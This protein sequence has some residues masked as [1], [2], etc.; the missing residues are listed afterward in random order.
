MADTTQEARD[1][2]DLAS[3]LPQDHPL[4]RLGR[5]RLDAAVRRHTQEHPMTETARQLDTYDHTH[6]PDGHPLQIAGHR[7]TAE[8]ACPDC[9]RH[10]GGPKHPWQHAIGCPTY[11]PHPN[12]IAAQGD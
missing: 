2:A 5:L 11:A 9:G 10:L 6:A 3:L 12:S 4:A 1:A 7:D 8:P